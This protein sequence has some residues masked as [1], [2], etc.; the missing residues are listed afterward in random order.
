[1]HC[2]ALGRLVSISVFVFV[3]VSVSVFSTFVALPVSASDFKESRARGLLRCRELCRKLLALSGGLSHHQ[4]MRGPNPER[5]GQAGHQVGQPVSRR[6][7]RQPM[8]SITRV[9]LT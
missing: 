6:Q 2:L 7:S 9:E 1:M 3:S 8:P 4:H 5:S